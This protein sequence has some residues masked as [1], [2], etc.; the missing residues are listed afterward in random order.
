MDILISKGGFSVTVPDRPED[1]ATT[2]HGEYVY[3]YGWTQTLN[4]S[5]AGV[6]KDAADCVAL[7]ESAVAKKLERILAGKVSVREGGGRI[8][9]PVMAEALSLAEINVRAEWK[10]KKDAKAIAAAC[11][12]KVAA[13]PGY[14]LQAKDNVERNAKIAAELEATVGSAVA[15]LIDTEGLDAA[16]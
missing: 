2:L 13:N 9:D 7:C 8:S 1:L 11:R 12:A 4:D 10:G 5:V 3:H 16:A 15:E 6:D 14:M